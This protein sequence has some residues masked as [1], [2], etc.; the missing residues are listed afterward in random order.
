MAGRALGNL[1]A[2]R[3][4]ERARR[5]LRLYAALE[6]GVALLGLGLVLAL[7][8]VADGLAPLLAGLPKAPGLLDGA[9]GLAAFGL[10]LVPATAMGTTLPLLTR[11]LARHDTRFGVA[12]GRLYGWNTLGGVAGAVAGETV[13][14]ARLGLVGSAVVAATLNFVAAAV[15]LHLD[16]R[17]SGDAAALGSFA[18]GRPRHV[19]RLA[20]LLAAAFL[21]GAIL[22]GL[23][24]VWLRF[25]PLFV[26]GSQLVFALMLATIL[27][28]I[29]LGGLLAAAW[30]DRRPGAAGSLA[31]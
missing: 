20:R 14:I 8:R 7:P 17:S 30:L 11:A 5:P 4:W 1:I 6:T 9:R 29:G 21:G 18:T 26:F 3:Q 28:G 24:V 31:A 22:L 10:M 15:A 16:R 2:A 27:A 12:L 25:L 23:E 19:P 13:L